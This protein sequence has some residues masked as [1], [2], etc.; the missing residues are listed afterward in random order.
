MSDTG[1]SSSTSA[2]MMHLLLK[3]TGEFFTEMAQKFAEIENGGDIDELFKEEAPP[4]P[5]VVAQKPKKKPV[6]PNAPKRPLNAYS[7][8]VMDNKEKIRR[9][10]PD[11]EPKDLFKHMGVLWG[12]T[13]DSIKE[14]YKQKHNEQM[15]DYNKEMAEY[16]PE[17]AAK[18]AADEQK[19]KPVDT[20]AQVPSG[21]SA[22]NSCM[23]C[24]QKKRG[25][26]RLLPG[27]TACAN[28]NAEC[29]YGPPGGSTP[30]GGK[31]KTS[32]DAGAA[33]KKKAKA[34]KVTEV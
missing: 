1:E 13:P 25:C 27:C 10:N 4:A 6:D 18:K 3:K 8:F 33:G 29:D 24:R 7:M 22:T 23:R 31:R 20:N 30:G 16:D 34:G 9:E 15:E 11:L 28:A 32:E 21:S 12:N 2:K 14:E 5:V 19:K 17:K 26:D